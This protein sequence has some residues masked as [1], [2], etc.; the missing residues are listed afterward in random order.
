MK[1]GLFV[2]LSTVDLVYSLDEFPQANSKAV[3]GRQDLFAGG[4]ATNA[5]IAFAHLGGKATLV[6]VVGRH[7]LSGAIR[8]ELE[9]HSVELIDLNPSFAEAPA[10]SSIA[11]NRAGERSVV[12]AN[13]TRVTALT[14]K[15][16]HALLEGASILLVD[17]HFMQVCQA[18][19]QAAH[20]LGVRVVL[21]GGS[22]K[23]GT[24][25][26]LANVDSA[27]CSADFLP[28]GCSSQE[29][30]FEYLKSR[31]LSRVAI[32]HGAEPI[33][34]ASGN[35]SGT[36]PVPQVEALDTLGA[37]DIFH[38]AFCH[39]HSLGL[40]FAEALAAAAR[41]ASESCRFRGTR[42]WMNL[43]HS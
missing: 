1:K 39:F 15:P 25:E 9:R 37:G 43:I 6:S 38:G 33:H 18:W 12:S 16:D 8:E 32:T 28:P 29:E 22:W 26:L 31:G 34:F 19:S 30:V 40:G 14:A 41:V 23:Q 13:A 7:L 10:I 20:E 5:S 35:L 17:G 21:D 11:V 24:A 2:G 42:E 27:I 3:A 36:V 4:P